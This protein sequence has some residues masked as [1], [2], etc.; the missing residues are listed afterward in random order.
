MLIEM[1]HECVCVSNKKQA[2]ASLLNTGY[3]VAG[4]NTIRKPE[5]HVLGVAIQTNY[6]LAHDVSNSVSHRER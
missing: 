4:S 3:D 1:D 6:R 2:G 5:P